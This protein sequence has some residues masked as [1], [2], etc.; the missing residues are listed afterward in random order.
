M[1]NCET[2][3]S[4]GVRSDHVP[5][6][7]TICAE[8][9]IPKKKKDTTATTE[10]EK[11]DGKN[12]KKNKD[13]IRIV[14]N[15]KEW[16]ELISKNLSNDSNPPPDND[17]IDDNDN[18]NP[19]EPEEDYYS[20]LQEVIKTST[21][22]LLE[23]IEEVN[24]KRPTWFVLSEDILTKR[25]EERNKTLQKYTEEKNDDNKEKAKTKRK[26]LKNVIYEA[27]E[28]WLN[29][30]AKEIESKQTSPRNMWKALNKAKAREF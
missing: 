7:L 29:A 13:Y 22:E 12:R 30:K 15:K 10:D 17:R 19:T 5:I 8:N 9:S 28:R 21:D 27:K 18:T 6:T 20:Q 3:N 26:E 2:E 23:K 1:I 25:I 11:T 4:M 24:R 14:S 16:N